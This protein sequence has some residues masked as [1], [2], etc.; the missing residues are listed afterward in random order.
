MNDTAAF[1]VQDSVLSAGAIEERLLPLYGL[2]PPY[3]C[4]FFRKGICDTYQIRSTEGRFYL[5]VYRAGRRSLRDVSEEARLLNHLLER[6]VPVVRPAPR[7]D[8]GYV[9]E[10]A[11]PEGARYSVLFHAVEGEGEQTDQ[12]R[13]ALGAA[14]ARLHSAA[15]SLT[16]A[17]DR[18]P[19]DMGTLVGENLV[20]IE[21]F[22]GHRPE[23]FS[24]IKEIADHASSRIESLLPC[25]PP[26][27]GV[28]HGDLHG[29][30]VR[31]DASGRPTLF[32]FDSSGIGW[33]AVDIGVYLCHEWM[34]TSPEAERVRQQRLAVF[35]EGYQTVRALGDHELAVVQLTPAIRHIFLMG[36]VLRHTTV[37]Q[38]WNWADDGF[39]DWHMKWFR[40]WHQYRMM[41]R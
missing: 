25:T 9:N 3:A 13:R 12:H 21:R 6:G 26:A 39:I 16:P 1:P 23:E 19:L 4:R 41:R 7:L 40:H 2:T 32:D 35:L 8:G 38:G 27:Y 17:Y 11:A 37:Y 18:Q 20:H 22:M 33:R 34:D 30:D 10:L 15:D 24:L 36:H 14:V 28:C 29:A 31:Y 5:K